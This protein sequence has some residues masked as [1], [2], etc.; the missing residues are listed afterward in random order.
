MIDYASIAPM[1]SLS[2]FIFGI[3]AVLLIARAAIELSELIEK[4]KARR[5]CTSNPASRQAQL[6]ASQ[7]AIHRYY[8]RNQYENKGA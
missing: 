2:T 8:N 5:D 7:K 3:I 4:R 6:S 1:M